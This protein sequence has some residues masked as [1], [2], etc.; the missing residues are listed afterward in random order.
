MGLFISQDGWWRLWQGQQSFAPPYPDDPDPG[1]I[2]TVD[3]AKRWV[4]QFADR[5]YFEFRDYPATFG[6]IY[7]LLCSGY[8]FAYKPFSHLRHLLSGIPGKNLLKI[9]QR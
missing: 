9:D 7:Q 1:D 6:K 3:E 5:L 4:Q 8:Q 2:D